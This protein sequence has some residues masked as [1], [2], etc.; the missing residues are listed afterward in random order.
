MA[1]QLIK[2]LQKKGDE[3]SALSLLV[4]QWG[5]DEKL[6]PKALQT[7][8]SL[9]SHFSRH[10]ESHS[11]Q[12]LINIERLLGE[13]GIALLSATDT[14]L[15]LEAAYWHDIGMVVSKSDLVE[16]MDD[17]SFTEFL[18]E[19]SRNNHHELHR[20][21]SVFKNQD[22]DTWFAGAD[23]PMQ[24]VDKFREL[25][26]EWFRRRHAERSDLIVN[27]PLENIGLSS[28]R[29]ELIP[30]RLFR[31]LGRICQMHGRPFS[32]ILSVSGL[33]FKQA[34]VAQDD[35]HPRFIA[36]LLRMGDLLDLDDNRFCPVMQCIA[37]E[38]RPALSKAHEEKHSAIRHLRIDRDRIE[39]K[40]ECSSI[41]GYIETC[42]WF[43]WLRE[44][45]QCQMAHWQDIVP[46]RK[47]GLLPTLGDLEV[48]LVGEFQV[49]K[50]GQ[51]PQ[52]SID[53]RKAFNLIQ[54]GNLYDTNFAYVR[55]VLQ[56]AVDAVL[57]RLWLSCGSGRDVDW[58][59]PSSS[60]R[61]LDKERIFVEL[62]EMDTVEETGSQS[63]GWILKVTD[64]GTGI[65]VEDL[66]YMLRIGASQENTR[67]Q[68][69]IRAMPEWLKPSGA[70]GI[71]LQSIFM[72]CDVIKMKTKDVFS[73]ES[74]EVLMHSPT[75][76]KEGLVFI[77]RK[78]S[79]ISVS[80]GTTVEFEFKI[81]AP[82]NSPLAYRPQSIQSSVA[83]GYDPIYGE[84]FS[85]EAASIADKIVEFAEGSLIPVEGIMRTVRHGE[86]SLSK[87]TR[88]KMS[89]NT[90]FDYVKY[91]DSIV[92][93]SYR[94]YDERRSVNRISVYYRGQS[95]KF[96]MAPFP[97]LDVS[98]NLMSGN[99]GDW[100]S[101]SRSEVAAS[102]KEK[103]EETIFLALEKKLSKDLSRAGG[104][105]EQHELN[106][107]LF[108][109]VMACR[110]GAGWRK[111]SDEL[112]DRWLDCE[113]DGKNIKM[114]FSNSDWLLGKSMS[115][116]LS[117]EAPKCLLLDHKNS[118]LLPVILSKW[119]ERKRSSV[120][121]LSYSDLFLED[122]GVEADL[123]KKTI[124]N[125]SHKNNF[126]KEAMSE[127]LE[128]DLKKSIFFRMNKGKKEPY[129]SAGV[130]ARLYN[131][132]CDGFTNQRFTL[133]IH[134]ML[135]PWK[136]LELCINACTRIEPVFPELSEQLPQILL[137]FLFRREVVGESRTVE[138]CVLD[139]VCLYVQ[140]RLVKPISLQR[141]KELYVELIVF[142]DDLMAASP[143][144]E[145]WSRCR[146]LPSKRNS[147]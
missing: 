86:F 28:P 55:E 144:S 115:R 121:A 114:F 135:K 27:S 79:D 3:H 67:R 71:G 91:G 36:C 14:W 62:I 5:F 65:G 117:S 88:K 141:I 35:C 116:D 133:V 125:R 17:E 99:A 40:A 103:L 34:G 80:S 134:P 6:I 90:D 92:G 95:F 4:S 96:E 37:G 73:N 66:D 30:A 124:R 50:E 18:E 51:R 81:S 126:L 46:S 108:L 70:F 72:V 2:H 41:E 7:I 143:F 38:G 11:R 105:D 129:T 76:D 110:Y 24:A 60:R 100:V 48:L 104:W 45:M 8:S 98:I 31:M 146:T 43:G 82:K 74:L 139:E 112:G 89:I 59:S 118:Y 83:I 131:L 122:G 63:A 147:D 84:S 123:V 19:I 85:Y 47:L 127:I 97:M 9:F 109:A 137:P 39:I 16:A 102:A 94:L 53:P 138:C 78:P 136:E 12:I 29:T 111:L 69:I 54:G 64:T 25:M 140:E 33:P 49:L 145:E 107:S 142:L 119:Q 56:N 68:K 1:D 52:F 77:K 20:F 44:E 42:K 26:S 13:E 32:E 61:I 106:I 101:A 23:S 132:T 57:V 58:S 87:A 10:D 22:A 75:S 128:E 113:L 21:V 120:T 15:L 130:A 93:V